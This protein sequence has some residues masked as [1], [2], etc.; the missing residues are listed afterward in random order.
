MT[1][2]TPARSTADA[3][4]EAARAAVDEYCRKGDGVPVLKTYKDGGE[5]YWS[6]TAR[7]MDATPIMK[8]R[9]AIIA[10]DRATAD[11]AAPVT[12]RPYDKIK[13]GLLDALAVTRL[14]N[15]ILDL[16]PP[17]VVTKD[18]HSRIIATL[19]PH[20][21]DSAAPSDGSN[22][23][24]A[25]FDC[26]RSYDDPGFCDLIIPDRAWEQIAPVNGDGLLCP[27]CLCARLR[28][29]GIECEGRFTSGPLAASTSDG[30]WLPV[31][32][33]QRDDGLYILSRGAEHDPFI[34]YYTDSPVIEVGWYSLAGAYVMQPEPTHYLPLSW[35]PEPPRSGGDDA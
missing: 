2:P 27:S 11:S 24:A 9:D 21:A 17:G 1:H 31:T 29:K 8:L 16:L 12:E 15:Q 22:P 5:E 26:G 33:K 30:G 20:V 35:L 19:A 7:M 4:I 6:P 23:A 14:A 18:L 25:C 3:V 13:A 34:G 32:D 28:T 10:H